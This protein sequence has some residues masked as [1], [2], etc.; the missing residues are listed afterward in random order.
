M[1]KAQEPVAKRARTSDSPTSEVSSPEVSSI[2]TSASLQPVA[3]SASSSPS[4]PAEDDDSRWMQ[5]DKSKANKPR[6][7]DEYQAILPAVQPKPVS[8]DG[9]DNQE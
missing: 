6:I 7:G 2:F 4:L 9:D 3:A 1:S 5:Y 8:E